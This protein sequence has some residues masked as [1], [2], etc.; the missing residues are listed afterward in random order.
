MNGSDIPAN[1]DK[2]VLPISV[3]NILDY[4]KD[5]KLAGLPQNVKER[6]RAL[7]L[8]LIG[9]AAVGYKTPL[10]Q[11]ACMTA[12]E[13]YATGKGKKSVPILFHNG[14]CSPAGAAFAGANMIDSIDSHDHH[15][16]STGHIGCSLLPSILS[17]LCF[18]ERQ[19]DGEEFL[20]CL[21]LGYE[22]GTRI[23]MSHSQIN[24]EYQSSGAWMGM[25]IAAIVC[26][27]Y[28][29]DTKIMYEAMGIAENFGPRS[30]IMK[31][32][33][34]TTMLKDASGW[35]A[36]AGFS[37]AEMAA[38]GFT[39]APCSAI[40]L[41]E[42]QSNWMDL[43]TKWYTLEPYIKQ[44]PFCAW[45]QAATQAIVNLYQKTPFEPSTIESIVIHTFHESMRLGSPHPKTSDEAQYSICWP[46][47]AMCFALA[48]GRKL[49]PYDISVDALNRLDIHQLS[50]K[51]EL[52]V[53]EHLN[54]LFPV[55]L[56]SRVDLKLKDGTVLSSDVT[57]GKGDPEFPLS[58]EE[59]VEKF[60]FMMKYSSFFECSEE[61]IECCMNL[62]E[63]GSDNSKQLFAILFNTSDMVSVNDD[64]ERSEETIRF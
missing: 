4:I 14:V 28:G 11:I 21:V 42:V 26:R 18:S 36:M 56:L 50:D 1:V 23:G 41:P 61:I 63:P 54:S 57:Y 55:K 19:E 43:G 37:A 20:T 17:A 64:I 34:H 22:L 15:P 62:G 16:S 2:D 49:G 3:Q 35:G 44:W 59:V 12:E 29:L 13:N 40:S 51:I 46:V 45:A 8:D 39:G 47:A 7:L 6:A 25:V 32:V 10:S 48:E 60:K 58:N 33:D 53:D 52:K 27:I 38:K 31:V 30:P 9:V 24:V 5:T